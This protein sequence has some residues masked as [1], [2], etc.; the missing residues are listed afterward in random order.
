MQFKITLTP[1]QRETF[2]PFNY[3]YAL[4]A[5]IYQKL[6]QADEGYAD[7]L[8][9]KGYAQNE[10]SRHFKFFTFSNLQARFIAVKEALK[11]QSSSV[12]FILACHMPEFAENLVKGVFA[13]QNLSIG[14]R[15]AQADFTVTQIE[16]LP[17]LVAT[18]SLEPINTVNLKL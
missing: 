3:P 6:A 11:L 14:D 18:N 10:H 2:V 15:T 16:A 4:S 1:V 7:F 13:N 5:V 8:H 12:S 17:S 9:Q